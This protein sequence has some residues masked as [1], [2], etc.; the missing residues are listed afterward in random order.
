M[1]HRNWY[2]IILWWELRRVPYNLIMYIAGLLSFYISY[3]SIPLIY[4]LMGLTFNI[5][6]TFGWIFELLIIRKEDGEKRIKYPKYIFV[7]YL[8]LSVLFV[9]GLALFLLII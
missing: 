7:G 1:S 6:Y 8:V 3:I 5:V 2:E 9:F 4:V